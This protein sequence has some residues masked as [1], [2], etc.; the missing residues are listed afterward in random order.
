MKTRSYLLGLLIAFVLGLAGCQD[1]ITTPGE[2]PEKPN[3]PALLQRSKDASPSPYGCFISIATPN[4]PQAYRYWRMRLEFPTGAL[5]TNGD[6]AL[7]QFRRYGH[8]NRVELL[9]NCVI[10][11]TELALEMV[12]RRFHVPGSKVVPKPLPSP[13]DEVTT[14]DCYKQT[15][16]SYICDGVKGGGG[17]DGG[18]ICQQDP[19]HWACTGGE[20][21]VVDPCEEDR[22]C[23]EEGAGST[24]CSTCSPNA[25]EPC[26]TGDATIDDPAVQIGYRNLW[27]ASNADAN[28][29]QRVE[30]GGWIVRT[31]SGSFQVE[32]WTNM[33]GN[34]CGMSGS[35]PPPYSGTIVGFIHTHPYSVGED[36][37][38]CEWQIVKYEGKPSSADRA[39]SAQLGPQFGYGTGLPG[40]ILDKNGIVKFVGWTEVVDQRHNRC[41]F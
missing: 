4:G 29:A 41:G 17:G 10:P 26:N 23:E 2:L 28:L 11:R 34:Y 27:A 13:I 37:V 5:A 22:S 35:P 24:P 7:A 8:G 15:D 36:V 40:Y 18:S 32:E 12:S 6:T 21:P 33:S 9:A 3:A 20:Q 16:G 14:L 25:P 31:P 39:T 19:S 30:R 1:A 38:N